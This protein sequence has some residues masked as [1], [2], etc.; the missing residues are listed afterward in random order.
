V[1]AVRWWAAHPGEAARMR[2]QARLA[3]QAKYTAAVNY[4]EL[5]QIYGFVLNRTE[6]GS[7]LAADKPTAELI[8]ITR[9]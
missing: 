2:A 1:D 4:A 5:M 8:N 7:Q 6:F 3:Y 9:P